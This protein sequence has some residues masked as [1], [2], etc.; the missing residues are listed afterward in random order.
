MFRAT[1][2]EVFFCSPMVCLAQR[3]SD[4]CGN[5]L[6]IHLEPC[7]LRLVCDGE[8]VA[9]EKRLNRHKSEIIF[10]AARRQGDETAS[11]DFPP[12]DPLFI[13]R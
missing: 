4:D 6:L 2:C 11:Q 10:T 1:G 8:I 7:A 13:R 5:F 9:A 12:A 3:P